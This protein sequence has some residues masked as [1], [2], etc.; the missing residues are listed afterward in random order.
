MYGWLTPNDELVNASS[1]NIARYGDVLILSGYV[2]LKATAAGNNAILGTF[3]SEY[4]PIGTRRM[5]GFASYGGNAKDFYFFTLES[6][7]ELRTAT[8]S[9][10]FSGQIKFPDVVIFR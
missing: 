1:L 9:N 10:T 8:G 6:N 2:E 3:P 5:H 7:G 4:S